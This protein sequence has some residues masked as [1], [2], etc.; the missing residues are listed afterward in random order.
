MSKHTKK[1]IILLCCPKILLLF[2]MQPCMNVNAK[3]SPNARNYMQ[4][5]YLLISIDTTYK[6]HDPNGQFLQ[7]NFLSNHIHSLSILYQSRTFMSWFSCRHGFL[8]K[9]PFSHLASLIRVS[10][11]LFCLVGTTI[12]EPYSF[13]VGSA[14]SPSWAC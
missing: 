10:Y 4:F 5:L 6:N 11:H 14:L 8:S 9:K 7:S 2:Q 3:G 1:L 13:M 12:N